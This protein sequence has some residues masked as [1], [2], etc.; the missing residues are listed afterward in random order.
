MV[1][2]NKRIAHRFVEEV[3]NGGNTRLLAELVSTDH[4]SHLPLGDHYGPE[5]VRIDICGF[6]S[7]FPDL[8]LTIESMVGEAD[9]VVYRFVARGTHK[10]PFMGVPPSGRRIEIDGISMDR[11]RDGQTIERWLQYDTVALLQQI[12]SAS[13]LSS[14]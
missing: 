2:Q 6:R 7:A 12:G 5:G 9:Y 3:I 11:L 10:G 4:V 14:S 8:N 1:E 13:A